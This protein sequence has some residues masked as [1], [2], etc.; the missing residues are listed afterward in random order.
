MAAEAARIEAALPRGA[1]RVALDERG[2]ARHHRGSWP[3]A[4]HAWQRDGRDVALVIG[5]PDGLDPAPE[6]RR[7]RDACA[8][9]T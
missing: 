8:C 7:R 4:L 6:G 9:P 5:G 3:S 1:R 2:T